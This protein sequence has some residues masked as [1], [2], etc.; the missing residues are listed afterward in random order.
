M[1][2][3]L[4]Y[5]VSLVVLRWVPRAWHLINRPGCGWRRKSFSFRRNSSHLWLYFDR[6]VVCSEMDWTKTPS[7]CGISG[8]LVH[9]DTQQMFRPSLYSY[10]ILLCRKSTMELFW[11]LKDDVRSCNLASRASPLFRDKMTFC[12]SRSWIGEL[13]FISVTYSGQDWTFAHSWVTIGLL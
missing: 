10:T 4:H 13:R 6:G 7:N 3:F 1:H 5:A 11:N 12:S 9:R 8:T 2:P